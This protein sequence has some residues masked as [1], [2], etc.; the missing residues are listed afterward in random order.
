M[1]LINKSNLVIEYR[2]ADTSK[3]AG[4]VNSGKIIRGHIMPKNRHKIVYHLP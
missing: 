2:R 3:P 4:S 1:K